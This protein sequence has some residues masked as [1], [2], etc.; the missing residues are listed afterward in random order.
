MDDMDDLIVKL[1]RLIAEH[2]RM[3]ALLMRLKPLKPMIEEAL[4][5]APPFSNSSN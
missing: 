3:K 2:K 5:D 4:K 1:E